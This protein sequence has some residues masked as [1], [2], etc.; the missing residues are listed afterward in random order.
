MYSLCYLIVNENHVRVFISVNDELVII[1]DCFWKYK[2]DECFYN[3]VPDDIQLQSC[4]TCDVDG[5]NGVPKYSSSAP[6]S[7]LNIL[8]V[9]FSFLLSKMP[10]F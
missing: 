4:M 7:K 3:K 2:A 5:C 1:R 8:G 9:L 6:F 10:N